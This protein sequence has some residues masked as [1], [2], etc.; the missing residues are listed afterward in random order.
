MTKLLAAA[1][2]IA[3]LSSP[4]ARMKA[5]AALD[6]QVAKAGL[7]NADRLTVALAMRDAYKAR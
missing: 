7:S 4:M 6:A 5:M 3:T 1:R 2:K